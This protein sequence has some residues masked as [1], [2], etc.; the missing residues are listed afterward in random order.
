MTG[1]VCFAGAR[2][3]DR[4]RTVGAGGMGG[5]DSA[6]LQPLGQDPHAVTV[7]AGLQ[8]AAKGAGL[9][10]RSAE[11]RVPPPPTTGAAVLAGNARGHVRLG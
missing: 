6:V 8:G 4:Y 10:G 5:G 7:P 3:R 2:R 11:P 9:N 1:C